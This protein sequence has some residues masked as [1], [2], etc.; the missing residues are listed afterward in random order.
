M[1]RA[2][3]QSLARD[4]KNVHTDAAA[5]EEAGLLPRDGSKLIARGYLDG[6]HFLGMTHKD[7]V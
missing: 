6:E 4:C 5:L 3:A 7:P 2:L 1:V